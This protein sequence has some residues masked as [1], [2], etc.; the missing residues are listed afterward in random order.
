MKFFVS[1]MTK[2]EVRE[3]ILS[4]SERYQHYSFDG[5]KW[6]IIRISC[7]DEK[8]ILQPIHLDFDLTKGRAPSESPYLHIN[9]KEAKN[10]IYVDCQ[11]KWQRKILF[12]LTAVLF[13]LSLGVVFSVMGSD[14]RLLFLN[15]GLI[16]FVLGWIVKKRLRNRKRYELF[17]ELMHKNF[18]ISECR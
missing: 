3:N 6:K 10:S 5:G 8:I 4:F 1:G 15:G 12:L 16:I 9:I 7:A 2:D 13:L 18:N 14:F 17:S 11:L